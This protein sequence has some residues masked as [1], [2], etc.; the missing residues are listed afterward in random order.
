MSVETDQVITGVEMFCTASAV[1][2]WPAAHAH[3]HHTPFHCAIFCSSA[4]QVGLVTRAGT[5]ADF[6]QRE[7]AGRVFGVAKLEGG[8]LVNRH[9]NGAGCRTTRGP[10]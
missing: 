1:A 4:S 5:V 8:R 6:L 9:C 7:K 3:G 2:A 10:A